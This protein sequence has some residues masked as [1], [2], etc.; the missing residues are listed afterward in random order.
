MN[1]NQIINMITRMFFRKIISRGMNAGIDYAT[2][3]GKPADQMTEQ[4]RAQAGSQ[5]QGAKDAANMARR[6][7]RLARRVGRM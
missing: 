6:T 1:S 4:D 7:T 5:A 3:R 2:R